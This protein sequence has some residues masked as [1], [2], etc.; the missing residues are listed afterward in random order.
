MNFLSGAIYKLL[1]GTDTKIDDVETKIDDVETKIDAI[2][3]I[4]D[5]IN[6]NTSSGSSSVIKSIQHVIFATSTYGSSYGPGGGLG[7]VTISSVITNKSFVIMVGGTGN[8]GLTFALHSSTSII[9]VPSINAASWPATE[10]RLTV[11]EFN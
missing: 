7:S 4:V 9:A 11:V 10:V 1:K 8:I 3:G 6:T 2:D 5:N